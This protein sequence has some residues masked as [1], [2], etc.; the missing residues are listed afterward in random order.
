[1]TQSTSTGRD[2][3]PIECAATAA[4]PAGEDSCHAEVEFRREISAPGVQANG[5]FHV[6]DFL[7][8]RSHCGPVHTA[9]SRHRDFR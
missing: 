5:G 6:T 3:S 7:S 9:R 1:M 4:A 8:R 2:G